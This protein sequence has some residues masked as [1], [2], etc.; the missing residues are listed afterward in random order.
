MARDTAPQGLD[1]ALAGRYEGGMPPG[2]LE[3][4]A[5]YRRGDVPL[6][7][8]WPARKPPYTSARI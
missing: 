3:N 7:L 5:A 2:W 1:Q 4:L 8:A 6:M